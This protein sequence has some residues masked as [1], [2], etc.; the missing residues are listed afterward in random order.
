MAPAKVFGALF[1][2]PIRGGGELGV[3]GNGNI[4]C[5]QPAP[6]VY[7][8]TFT[9]GPDNRLVTVSKQSKKTIPYSQ[10]FFTSLIYYNTGLLQSP[11]ARSRHNRTP[12]PT[13]RSNHNLLNP[14]IL[15]QRHGH[16]PLT[17]FARLHAKTTLRTLETFTHLPYAYH[18]T[19]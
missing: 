5:T 9:N 3:G 1:E 19:L 14:Q 4:V 13:R 6:K 16:L 17:I 15:L 12:L 7:L 18:R 11:H 10:Y 2:L 8:L